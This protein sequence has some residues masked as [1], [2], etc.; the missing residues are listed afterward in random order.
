MS[1]WLLA[2]ISQ[3]SVGDPYGQSDDYPLEGVFSN[4]TEVNVQ[5]K[6]L[7]TYSIRH[8]STYIPANDLNNPSNF[9]FRVDGVNTALAI[10]VPS[11]TTGRF[12]DLANSVNV[13]SG[14][15]LS[16]RV[17]RPAGGT[18]RS[19]GIS[20]EMRSDSGDITIY[21]A[22][23]GT[24]VGQT[25]FD[26]KYIPVRG[27]VG[28]IITHNDVEITMRNAPTLSDMRFIVTTFSSDV[29]PT[30]ALFKNGSA[31]NQTVTPTGTG[32]FED[33]SNTDSYIATDTAA[34]EIDNSAAS[35]GSMGFSTCHFKSDAT[36]QRYSNT[37]TVFRIDADAANEFAALTGYGSNNAVEVGKEIK[38][39]MGPFTLKDFHVN[40][41][42]NTLTTT[43]NIFL[44][45]NGSDTS[46][47]VAISSTSTGIFED[48]SNTQKVV[49]GDLVS[50]RGSAASGTGDSRS[51]MA[52]SA[53]TPEV[54][55]RNW[56]MLT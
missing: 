2:S 5:I 56:A 47:T 1:R 54:H 7:D 40:C 55:A 50:Y 19:T 45:V 27:H 25:P 31:V 48:T 49:S 38:F 41:H 3:S 28:S 52:I 12:Q 9:T 14:E 32:A 44:R 46:I 34:V 17:T 23:G 43:A 20:I 29:D 33:T 15:L 36:D 24:S 26:I 11:L 30:V 10:A 53:T 37:Q 6:V 42:L 4:N 13:V 21:S 51:S 8:M 16:H 39:Q 35:S 22:A 18:P